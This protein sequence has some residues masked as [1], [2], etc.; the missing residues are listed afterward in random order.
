MCYDLKTLY[1]K[2]STK[3]FLFLCIFCFEFYMSYATS[4]NNMEVFEDNLNL[5]DIDRRSLQ[6]NFASQLNSSTL[7]PRT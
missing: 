4:K 7:K 6:H 2:G 3:T 5:N 1:K